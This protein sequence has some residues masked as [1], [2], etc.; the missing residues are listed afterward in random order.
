MFRKDPPLRVRQAHRA[1]GQGV[2]EYAGALVIATAVIAL[3]LSLDPDES[4]TA[5]FHGIIN[6]FSEY[7]REEI[8]NLGSA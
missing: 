6:S 2:V 5:M 1:L 8:S 7:A 4:A 3:V